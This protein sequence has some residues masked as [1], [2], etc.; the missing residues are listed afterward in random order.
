MSRVA[1][2]Q[3][4][5]HPDLLSVCPETGGDEEKCNDKTRVLTS[6]YGDRGSLSNSYLINP[7]RK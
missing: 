1:A 7:V 3:T 5:E 4:V 2:V 6:V